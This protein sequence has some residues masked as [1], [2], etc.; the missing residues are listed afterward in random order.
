MGIEIIPNLA[1]ANKRQLEELKEQRAKLDAQIEKLGGSS[2]SKKESQETFD[3]LTIS[4]TSPEGREIKF[5]LQEQLKYWKDFY[6]DENVNW[7][8]LPDNIKITE[9]QQ[10]EMERLITKLGFD[11][12]IIIPENLSATPDNREELNT[13]MADETNQNEHFKA[14]GG[15][16]G[17]ENK[18]NKLTI[19]LTKDV[20]ELDHDQFFRETLGLTRDELEAPGGI[21]AKLG[22]GGL[23]IDAYEV[24]RKKI[25]KKTGNK[26]DER[27]ATWLPGSETTSGCVP[28]AKS[29]PGDGDKLSFAAPGPDRLD[30]WKLTSLGCRMAVSFEV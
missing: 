9:A 20:L 4:G 29:Y 16:A 5:E 22:V 27:G 25:Y 13:L 18:S 15:F 7:I 1:D 26:L 28:Y 10:K 21:L 19:I 12:M 3:K 6:K 24:L 2:S 14:N 8:N 11:E 23:G 17:F 30:R